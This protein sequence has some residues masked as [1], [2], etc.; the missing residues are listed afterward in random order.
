MQCFPLVAP[1]PDCLYRRNMLSLGATRQNTRPV[2]RPLLLA[3]VS[4]S[5]CRAASCC[6]FPELPR[7]HARLPACCWR[8]R[9]SRVLGPRR[10]DPRRK[11]VQVRRDRP[12]QRSARPRRHPQEPQ[13]AAPAPP[14]LRWRR[15]H[16][17][18][19]VVLYQVGRAECLVCV[20]DLVSRFRMETTSGSALSV[21][22]GDH[23]RICTGASR[24]LRNKLIS[25]SLQ[26]VSVR[27]SSTRSSRPTSAAPTRR[28]ART[29]AMVRRT[30]GDRET[31]RADLS[32]LRL[33]S[34][35][36]VSS[37]TPSTTTRSRAPT[38]TRRRISRR[39]PSRPRARRATNLH[40]QSRRS[41]T[42]ASW[43]KTDSRTLRVPLAGR[44]TPYWTRTR[45]TR[46][47]RSSRSPTPVRFRNT[48][49]G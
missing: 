7:Q 1:V 33:K 3:S 10:R 2:S 45:P 47:S 19:V 12:R 11:H 49:C 18:L 29:T 17:H 48:L 30:Y 4:C 27:T 9:Q 37:P 14:R 38:A 20:N 6:P 8:C 16:D 22:H 46:S 43:A 13:G 25:V 15:R 44:S 24:L 41:A 28:V 42:W 40:T 35:C 34:S 36:T 26:T 21:L 23:E 31:R 39:S 5:S 32:E